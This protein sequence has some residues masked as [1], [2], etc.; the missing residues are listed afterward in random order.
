MPDTPKLDAVSR[1]LLPPEHRLTDLHAGMVTGDGSRLSTADGQRIIV[2]AHM[3]KVL[4]RQRTA[5]TLC[6]GPGD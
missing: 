3:R 1:A 6:N 2:P 4:A 5:S